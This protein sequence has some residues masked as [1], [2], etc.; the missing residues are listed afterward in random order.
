MGRYYYPNENDALSAKIQ[1]L[2][3]AP[4]LSNTSIRKA[5]IKLLYNHFYVH[6]FKQGIEGSKA[7]YGK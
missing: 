4:S 3:D 7:Y 5:L 1:F 2:W 6:R